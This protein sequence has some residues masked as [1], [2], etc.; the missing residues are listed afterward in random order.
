MTDHRL[1]EAPALD[2]SG[3]ELEL[4]EHFD[5]AV[6][7]ERVWLPFYLPQWSS[8]ERTAGR[9][10]VGGASGTTGLRLRIDADQPPWA[11]EWD[12]DLRVSN[13][14]TGVF[15]GPPGT[16]IGQHRFRPDVVVREAQEPH[17]LFTPQYGIVELRA[18]ALAD[19]RVL[20][21]FWLI[22]FEDEPERSAE[23][24]V[25]EVFGRDIAAGLTKVGV[26]VHPFGDPSI[27]DD[28]EKV[29]LPIDAR[30]AHTYS[31]EWLPDQVR[32]F[33]DDSIVKVVDQAPGYPMQ[34]MLN[35][36]EFPADD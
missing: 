35:I 30:D 27:E 18:R 23:I 24:C 20:S 7:D 22:G 19:P 26:G 21:A 5:G 15:A 28:F 11:P 33:V 31:A 12:G 3:Y 34:L 8:R 32:F 36:Y 25:M 14:Q 6:L 10:E 1:S 9:Y 16:N 4:D 17:A 13:L 29:E 2:R